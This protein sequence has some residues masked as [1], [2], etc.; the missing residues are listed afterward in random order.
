MAVKMALMNFFIYFYL[1]EFVKTSICQK[2][3]LANIFQQILATKV[4][5]FFTLIL[6]VLFHVIL[7]EGMI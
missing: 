3:N 5:H 4:D 7:C 2:R 6:F 1:A